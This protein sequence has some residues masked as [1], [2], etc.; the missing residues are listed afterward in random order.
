MPCDTVHCPTNLPIDR[1]VRVQIDDNTLV[2]DRSCMEAQLLL[3]DDPGLIDGG[4]PLSGDYLSTDARVRVIGSLSDAA[5]HW[6]STSETYKALEAFFIEYSRP[7]VI[8]VGFISFEDDEETPV[9]ALNEIVKCDNCWYVINIVHEYM[10]GTTIFDNLLL[11]V[12][13]E[14]AEANKKLFLTDSRDI[15]LQTP[16]NTTNIAYRLWALGLRRTAVFYHEGWCEVIIDNTGAEIG[17]ETVYPYLSVKAGAYICGSDLNEVGSA[18][19]LKFKNFTGVRTSNLTSDIVTSV[20]GFIPGTGLDRQVG[21]FANMFVQLG[22]ERIMVEGTTVSGHFIDI[23]HALDW[24]AAKAQ[25]SIY[26]VLLG[27]TSDSNKRKIPY[28]ERGLALIDG[29]LIDL[30]AQATASGII[31]DDVGTGFETEGAEGEFLGAFKVQRES[32]NSQPLERRAQRLSPPYSMCF[33][34]AGAIHWVDLR[35]C[36]YA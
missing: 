21:H 7:V 32:V 30:G 26:Q 35:Q 22:G 19:T 2:F 20:T 27:K 16:T 6:E 11:D 8:K 29:A 34:V 33:R 25:Q 18:Y 1:V 14:W 15:G 36:A 17:T 13:A 10:D 5:N 31:S 12:V 28:T 24:L 4:D 9:D 23:V 3:T